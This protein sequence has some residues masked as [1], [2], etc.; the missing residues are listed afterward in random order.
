MAL[1]KKIIGAVVAIALVLT[2]VLTFAFKADTTAVD[3][4]SKKIAP[5]TW[6]FT[7]TSENQVLNDAFWTDVNPNDPSCTSA[8]V[9]LPC[10]FTVTT[11]DIN[12]S[13]ELVSYLNTTYSGDEGDIAAAADSRKPEL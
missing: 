12:D 2:T 4:S 8:S 6:Y 3:V 1:T 13:E 7:G 5:T 9:A 10:Q 11:E